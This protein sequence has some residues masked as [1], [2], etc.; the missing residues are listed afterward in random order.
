MFLFFCCFSF[1]PVSKRTGFLNV[2]LTR[3]LTCMSCIFVVLGFVFNCLVC[4]MISIY[5]F[6]T[7]SK[8]HRQSYFNSSNCVSEGTFV[9]KT[10]LQ[11][12]LF[13]TEKKNCNYLTSDNTAILYRTIISFG[14]T[15]CK[16]LPSAAEKKA[17]R[18]KLHVC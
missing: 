1:S 17:E 7:S 2:L 12:L 9:T 6:R 13:C 18:P 14:A 3:R 10:F 15:S 8:Q 16:E 11:A 5:T 4:E